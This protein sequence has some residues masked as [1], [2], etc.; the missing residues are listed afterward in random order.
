MI[1][2]QR[3]LPPFFLFFLV[4][5]NQHPP[6]H[7]IH[8]KEKLARVSGIVRKSDAPF[9]PSSSSTTTTKQTNKQTAS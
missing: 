8:I 4:G 6:T 2:Q 3:T 5:N 9:G 7:Q 1:Q